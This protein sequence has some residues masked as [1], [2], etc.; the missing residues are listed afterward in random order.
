MYLC[1]RYMLLQCPVQIVYFRLGV[2]FYDNCNHNYHSCYYFNMSAA[3]PLKSLIDWCTKI[4]LVKSI[5]SAQN[6]PSIV[7]DWLPVSAHTDLLAVAGTMW[8]KEAEGGGVRGKGR[9]GKE[10]KGSEGKSAQPH[11]FSKVGAH[12]SQ[13]FCLDPLY[14][15]QNTESYCFSFFLNLCWTHICVRNVLIQ[16]VF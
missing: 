2:L 9:K 7:S 10:M 4:A 11:N 15:W 1:K 6:K 13:E 3:I 8:V 12:E 5:F 14:A 16:I